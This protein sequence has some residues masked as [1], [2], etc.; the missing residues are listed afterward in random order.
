V[1]NILFSLLL[2]GPLGAPGL[3]LATALASM[4]NGTI[5]VA[6]LNRR[7]GSVDWFVVGRSAGRVLL[8]CTPVAAAC[9]WVA[10]VQ[11]WAQG[12]QWLL[13]SMLLGAGIGVSVAGYVGVHI[14]LKSDELDVFLG[15]VKR[16]LG[17]VANRFGGR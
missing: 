13:K 11:I 17:R 2:M 1:A 6:A 3:A 15:M 12:G 14:L 7:L 8:A 10:G 16:K 9:W 5:L 4:L